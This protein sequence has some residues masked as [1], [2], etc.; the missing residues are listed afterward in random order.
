MKKRKILGFNWGGRELGGRGKKSVYQELILRHLT[1]LNSSPKYMTTVRYLLCDRYPSLNSLTLTTRPR[2]QTQDQ[3][4]PQTPHLINKFH[5]KFPPSF[6]RFALLLRGL[7][8]V[9]P[10]PC[11]RAFRDA[12]SLWSAR[13][14]FSISDP[15]RLRGGGGGRGE[16]E[17]KS[18]NGDSI[19]CETDLKW[20]S[21]N[22]SSLF[23]LF[24]FCLFFLNLY[25]CLYVCMYLGLHN[26]CSIASSFLLCCR[27]HEKRE[28]ETEAF[29]NFGFFF[30]GR[31]LDFFLVFVLRFARPIW[32]RAKGKGSFY[33]VSVRH[34]R[35]SFLSVLETQNRVW[36]FGFGTAV[37][38]IIIIMFLICFACRRAFLLDHTWCMYVCLFVCRTSDERDISVEFVFVRGF[39]IDD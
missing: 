33:S 39:L 6:C 2:H 24:L 36:W 31:N 17:E 23:L 13:I 27:L 3:T 9:V 26:I 16:E 37:V 15:M 14:L 18:V 29:E 11:V 25:L 8:V 35:N 21:N 38:S 1:A 19:A 32:G 5:P 22:T 4:H 10:R 34:C 12:I 20:C 7:L 28:T 30:I